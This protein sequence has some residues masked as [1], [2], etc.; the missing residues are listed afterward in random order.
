MPKFGGFAKESL[1]FIIENSLNS[2]VTIFL[3]SLIL[4]YWG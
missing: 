3:S 2:I 1:V 4:G